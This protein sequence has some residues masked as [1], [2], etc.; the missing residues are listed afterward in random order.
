MRH[1]HRATWT[2]C[3]ALGG[4]VTGTGTLFAQ[5]QTVERPVAKEKNPLGD[6]PDSQVFIAYHSPLGFTLKVPEGWSR[7]DRTAGVRFSDKYGEIDVAVEARSEPISVATVRTVDVKKLEQSG[8]AVVI[9][10]VKSVQLPAGSAV[11]VT[12]AANSA[13]N[14]VT[15]KQIRLEHERYL[16]AHGGKVVALDFS[17]PAG[18]DN[19]DQWRLMSR[20]FAW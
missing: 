16:L 13:P 11:L 20:S 5:A 15:G 4:I 9:G 7:T 14:T 18:A 3:L 19:A 6:I 1:L 17:A 2:I 10:T 8:R 12:Y